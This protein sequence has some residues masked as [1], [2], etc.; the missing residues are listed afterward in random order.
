MSS[1]ELCLLLDCILGLLET[2]NSER[3]IEVI[4]NGIR[5]ID[6][7]YTISFD[8]H[9]SNDNSDKDEKINKA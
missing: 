3:A 4:K 5:R 2:G 8:V 9:D 1:Q 7:S 6:K